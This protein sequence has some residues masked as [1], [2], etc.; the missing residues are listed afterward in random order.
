MLQQ[1]CRLFCVDSPVSSVLDL[2]P[3][4]SHNCISLSLHSHPDFPTA[5]KCMV[6]LKAYHTME[7][8][9]FPS[10]FGM[11]GSH[12]TVRHFHY[13]AYPPFLYAL[14]C[15]VEQHNDQD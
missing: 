5:G 8:G 3:E 9:V 6:I 12:V 1:S 4:S 7:I 15:H 10:H 13:P 14:S 2:V 11:L